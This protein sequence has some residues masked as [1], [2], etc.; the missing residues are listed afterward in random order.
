MRVLMVAHAF[1]PTVGGVETYLWDLTNQLAKRG[2][3]AHCVVGGDRYGA[4]AGVTRH[5]ELS[6]GTPVRARGHLQRSAVAG[7]LVDRLTELLE[8]A[9]TG[10]WPDLLHVHNAHHF[11]PELAVAC[12]R[13]AGG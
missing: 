10:F 11:G 2:H 5:P 4:L 3:Q 12:F 1:P 6:P 13:A 9:V 7:E 8:A